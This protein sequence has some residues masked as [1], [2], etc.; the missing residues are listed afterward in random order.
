[1]YNEIRKCRACG[2]SD[3]SVLM[4]LG[5]HALSGYFPEEPSEIP[6]GPLKLLKCRGDCGL[7]QLAHSF[8]PSLMFG[9]NYGYRSGLNASMSEH[10]KTK[11]SD[12]LNLGILRDGDVVLDIGSNDGT[13]LSFY[14]DQTYKLIGIDPTASKFRQYYR[15][16][17]EIVDDFFSQEAFRSAAG[18]EKAKVITSFSMLYDLEDPVGFASQ[19]KSVLHD[20][21]VWIFEQSY[22]PTMLDRN[23]FDTICHEHLEYYGL[24]Q[25]IWILDRVGMKVVDVQL[26]EVNG[27]SFSVVAAAKNSKLPVNQVAVDTLTSREEE[28]DQLSLFGFENFKGRVNKQGDIL[29]DMLETMKSHG[30]RVCGLG[31]STKGN[32][33]LQY[34]SIGTDLIECVGEVNPDKFGRYT[35]GTNIPIQDEQ[36][37]LETGPDGLLVLPWHFKEFFIRNPRLAGQSLIFPLPN[38]IKHKV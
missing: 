23:S 32:T 14:P 22:L 19:V 4:D 26:N 1:M 11:V 29:I 33:L 37:V 25:I 38:A 20:E 18:S 34:F 8:E 27:G 35:P 12:I 13:T 5:M 3:F 2:S 6:M 28:I 9:D 21:G 10:L 36:K 17:V 16:D 15:P 7:V 31:A 30:Q 24:S